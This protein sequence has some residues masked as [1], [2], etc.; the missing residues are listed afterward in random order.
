MTCTFNVAEFKNDYKLAK[1][2]E[3]IY[4]R[5]VLLFKALED[6]VTASKS[7]VLIFSLNVYAEAKSTY[8]K[9]PIW[10]PIWRDEKILPNEAHN[11][12]LLRPSHK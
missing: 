9:H 1:A 7:D 3:P 6:S 12:C 8:I 11:K 4:S 5:L 2:L 10:K